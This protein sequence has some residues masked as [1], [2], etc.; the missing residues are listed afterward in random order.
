M[1]DKLFWWILI[2]IFA[3]WIALFFLLVWGQMGQY[4]SVAN[5]L[6]REKTSLVKYSRMSAEE[7]PTE[8]LVSQRNKYYDDWRRE[9]EDAERFFQSRD[10]LFSRGVQNN[11]SDWNSSYRDQWDNLARRY[12]THTG[13]DSDTEV[14]FGQLKDTSD[15][16]KIEMYEK[17]WRAQET[18]IRGVLDIPQSTVDDFE[19]ASENRS[20]RSKG[21]VITGDFQRFGVTL[22]A[23]M[24]PSRI[25]Q[26]LGTLLIDQRINFEVKKLNVVKDP[27][28]LRYEVLEEVP[29]GD[30]VS[31]E[32]PNVRV[33]LELE[34][35]DLIDKDVEN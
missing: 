3:G 26:F 28:Q 4:E 21:A 32:E 5:K 33:V 22:K 13:V 18:V 20:N 29:D 35:L 25:G 24:P 17:Q 30:E 10:E 8:K 14:P 16:T 34:V 12:R 6:K 27:R 11:L 23:A 15:T 31:D 9:V 1:S 2:A 7:L 19:F